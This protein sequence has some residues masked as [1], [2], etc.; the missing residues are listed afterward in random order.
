[1]GITGENYGATIEFMRRL[2]IITALSVSFA[3]SGLSVFSQVPAGPSYKSGTHL[4]PI[5]TFVTDNDFSPLTYEEARQKAGIDLLGLSSNQGVRESI[6]ATESF[7]DRIE[8]L[9]RNTD[10]LFYPV[11]RQTFRLMDEE[12]LVLYSFRDPNPTDIPSDLLAG[13]LTEFAFR[14]TDKPEQSRFGDSAGPEQLDI[15]GS[16]GLLF[17][18]AGTSDEIVLFWQDELASHV[19]V[20]P[21]SRERMFR[22]VTDLL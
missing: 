12:I 5:V 16:A 21:V 20:A 17:D 13:I 9:G 6:D 4:N 2:L 1:M 18:E 14:P 7:V 10:V 22:I 15:R 8:I 19:A 3:G 11:V